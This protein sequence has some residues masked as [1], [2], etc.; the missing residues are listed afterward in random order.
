MYRLIWPL[1]SVNRRTASRNV[2][3]GCTAKRSSE[4][5]E[6]RGSV[7]GGRRRCAVAGL[8]VVAARSGGV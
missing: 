3:G 1:E 8:A 7:T 5:S 2:F 4:R 6:S